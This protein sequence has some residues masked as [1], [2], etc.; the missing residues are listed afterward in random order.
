MSNVSTKTVP[1]PSVL[2]I[3]HVGDHLRKPLGRAQCATEIVLTLL[4]QLGQSLL[5]EEPQGREQAAQRRPHVV[6][7]HVH[8]VF[9]QLFRAAQRLVSGF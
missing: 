1:F 7:Q 2:V 8:Q 9:A 4:L 6:H 3:Q 5:F